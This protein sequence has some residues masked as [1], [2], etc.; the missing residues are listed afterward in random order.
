MAEHAEDSVTRSERERAPDDEPSMF[1]PGRVVGALALLAA[2]VALAFVFFGS[3]GYTYKLRFLTAGQLVSGN[4]VMIAGQRVGKVGDIV[5]TPNGQAEI[6]VSLSEP[7]A[8]LRQGTRATIRLTSLAGIAN[9]HVELQIPEGTAPEIPDGGVIDI[10]QTTTQVDV[11][12]LFNTLDPVARVA[13]QEFFKG[14]ARQFRGRGTQANAALRYLNPSLA[15]SSRLFNELNRDTPLLARFLQESDQLTTALA[16]RRDDLTQVITRFNITTRALGNKRLE[17]MESLERLPDFMRLANTTFVNL[18]GTLDEVDPLVEASKPVARKLPGFFDE[19][20]PLAR[21]ARPTLRDLRAVIRRPGNDND[22]VEVGRT[23]PPLARTALDPIE[24]NGENRP[25]AFPEISRGLRRGTPN[26]AFLK[27]YNVDFVGWQNDFS[28]SGGYDAMGEY[29]A[30][31]VYFN[32]F[33]ARAT[34]R[35]STTSSRR[36]ARS[37]TRSTRWRPSSAR[38]PAR[39]S[40]TSTSRAGSLPRPPISSTSSGPSSP[41]RGTAART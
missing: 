1:T 40:T 13:V 17:L 12:E 33:T 14:Q 41:R 27:Q 11:D 32:P 22:L 31:Q 4:D 25:G 2:M 10:D 30:S 19:L 9:R 5:I 37:T 28:K 6:G 34:T 18:R 29:A 24:R 21:D 35:A 8:P 16:T 23:L 15:T 38:R 3:S 26:Q 7:Y 20:R 36:S 39:P